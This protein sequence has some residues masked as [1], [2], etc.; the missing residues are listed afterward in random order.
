MHTFWRACKEW[1]NDNASFLGAAL[2]YYS[3]FSI[4]PLLLLAFAISGLI[5]GEAAAEGRVFDY[6]KEFVGA[7]SAQAVQQLVLSSRKPSWGSWQSI[8]ATTIL[9]YAA[10]SLFRQLKTALN[11][12]WKLPPIERHGIVGFI[13]DLL[14]AVILVLCTGLFVLFMTIASMINAFLAD[15]PWFHGLGPQTWRWVDLGA[16]CL[17]QAL[18]LAFT[19]R[20]LSEGRIAYRYVIGGALAAAIMLTLGKWAFSLYLGYSRLDTLYGAAGSMIV[21]LVWVYYSAQIVFFGAEIIKVQMQDGAL[22]P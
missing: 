9:V 20:V 1:N 6:L 13:H 11:V 8:L 5:L 2:A 4:A 18:I 14:L 10:L 7:D 22:A 16:I 12:V 15:L 3:L 19:Y 21:F 17:L